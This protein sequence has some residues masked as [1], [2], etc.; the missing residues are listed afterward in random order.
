VFFQKLETGDMIDVPMGDDDIFADQLMLQ[1]HIV[2]LFD[3]LAG[4]TI[5]PIDAILLPGRRVGVA[6][7]IDFCQLFGGSHGGFSGS[8]I[9]EQANFVD[10]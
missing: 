9:D 2:D 4:G 3:I 5:L 6:V 8:G 7:D 10:R 1:Q